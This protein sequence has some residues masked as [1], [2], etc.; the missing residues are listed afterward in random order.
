MAKLYIG[1]DG[2]GTRTTALAVRPDGTVLSRITGPGLNWLNDGLETC[3][4]RFGEMMSQ[5]IPPEG[6]R[7]TVICAGLAALDGPASPEILAAFQAVLP[8]RCVLTLESD[9]SVALCA[10]TAGEPGLMVVCGTGSMVLLRDSGGQEYAAGGWGWKV[11]DPGSGYA[12][13]REGLFQALFRLES[14][15]RETPLLA[16][17]LAFFA[18]SDAR[19]LLPLLYAPGAGPAALAAFGAEVVRLAESGDREAMGILA[20]QMDQLASLAASLL[21][22]APEAISRVGLSGGVFQHSALARSLFSGSLSARCPGVRPRLP[23]HSPA[24]G[25]AILAMLRDRI[26]SGGLPAFPEVN[27]P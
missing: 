19:S 26:P 14:E 25:A 2:G 23:D 17:A 4:R 16:A 10:L 22:W 7:E 11:G 18:A 9:L 20:G 6:G 21:R 5:L 8:A 13:A 24:L 1:V 3:V 15:S 27:H 12:L